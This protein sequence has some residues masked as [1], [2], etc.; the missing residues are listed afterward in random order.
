MNGNTE[1][2]NFIYQNSQMGVDTLQQ[3]EEICTDDALKSQLQEQYNNYAAI[4]EK[5]R[6][7]LNKNGFDEKGL[8]SL[9]KIR[10]YLTICI[11]TITDRSPSHLA[12][13]LIIGSTM[14]PIDA[15][16][17]LRDYSNAEQ[18]IRN[19]MDSLLEFEKDNIEKLK[20]YL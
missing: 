4:H 18:E 1:L 13:M 6:V 9:E 3:I 16:K 11:Q 20:Q 19:L 12:E 14:G 5:A 17:K 8:S 15:I 7:L 2:L 10:T